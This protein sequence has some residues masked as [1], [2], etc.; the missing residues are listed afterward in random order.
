MPRTQYVKQANAKI[1]LSLD[2][3]GILP[4]GYHAINTVMQSVDLADTVML[5]PADG[6]L[7]LS[8]SAPGIPTDGRNAAWKAAAA[9]C[10]AAGTAP[11]YHIHI[12]KR[13]PSEAGMGGG[14]AD[15]AAVLSILNGLHG[16]PL[17]ET[18]LL[19]LALEIGADV[20]FC[21]TGGTRLCL[22]KGEVM[23]PLPAFSAH[24]LIAK[25]N[26]GVSTAEAFRRFDTAEKL[27][28]PNNDGFLFHIARGE[29]PAAF[30]CA[31]NLFEQ[32]T[33]V[34]EGAAIKQSMLA[35]GAFYA[36]MTG[37]GSAFFGLFQ[38]RE[39][40]QTAKRALAGTVPFL[41]VCK[42]AAQ[43]TEP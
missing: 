9:F 11:D 30:R 38:T 13:I 31:G 42:T 37:S 22:D 23:A 18:E 3:T 33:D 16:A 28:H 10:R 17:G 7:S 29:I 27:A 26:R 5:T 39:E 21:L 20:P 2:L 1:N 12:E 32:L 15:A 40:A 25:P 36:A 14:S 34:P 8:C 6:G 4:D 24:V 35:N 19:A 41:E 43:G